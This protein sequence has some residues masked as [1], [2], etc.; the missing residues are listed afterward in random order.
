M[1]D[2]SIRLEILE[3]IFTY[4]N[5]K[6][7]IVFLFGSFARNEENR[8]SDIDI[9]IFTGRPIEHSEILNIREYIN[10]KVKTLRKID[11]VDFSRVSDKVFMKE[12]I[13]GAVL[14]YQGK[15]CKV[16]WETLKNQLQS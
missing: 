1:L 10:E 6:E 2:D 15:E 7:C 14:W 16:S 13:E 4:L 8:T 9:G 12:A 3:S 5:S 11:I